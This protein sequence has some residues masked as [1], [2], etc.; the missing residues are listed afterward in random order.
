MFEPALKLPS[1]TKSEVLDKLYLDLSNELSPDIDIVVEEGT[2][3]YIDRYKAGIRRLMQDYGAEQARQRVKDLT[4]QS[5]PNASDLEDATIEYYQAM[6]K[7]EQEMAT[8]SNLAGI[9]QGNLGLLIVSSDGYGG[10]TAEGE[11][12]SVIYSGF[13]DM[14]FPP[15]NTIQSGETGI[16]DYS[17]ESFDAYRS[18]YTEQRRK[19]YVLQYL[20]NAAKREI[21]HQFGLLDSAGDLGYAMRIDIDREKAEHFQ[22]DANPAYYYH[23]DR[24]GLLIKLKEWALQE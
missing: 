1:V 15:T 10:R 21:G 23:G 20:A 9:S 6:T 8:S 16:I 22:H 24:D 12:W 19:E 5:L 13:L 3:N 4:E 18:T 2:T 7:V 14:D 17:D 11:K